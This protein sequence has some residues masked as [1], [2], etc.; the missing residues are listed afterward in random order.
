MLSTYIK[1]QLALNFVVSCRYIN[2]NNNKK[3]F[4]A[5]GAESESLGGQRAKS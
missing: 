4:K 2:N 1:S 3:Y 5:T